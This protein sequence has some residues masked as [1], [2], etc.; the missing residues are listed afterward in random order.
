[1]GGAAAVGVACDAPFEEP[2]K[3][4]GAHMTRSRLATLGV[5]AMLALLAAGCGKSGGG[6]PSSAST[7]TQT[8]TGSATGNGTGG[9]AAQGAAVITVKSN[10]TY[11]KILAGGPKRLTLYM[12]ASDHG[13]ASTCYGACATVWPPLITTG[14]PKAQGG[15]LAAKLGTIKRTDGTLQVTYAGHP[16]YYYTP[17][18]TEADATGQGSTSFGAPWWVLSPTGAVIKKS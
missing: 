15:A 8:E 10:A 9:T 17:D 6:S 11:G 13:K 4:I 2:A 18:T 12:F 3:Q 16:L 5:L 14:A 7:S 1:M